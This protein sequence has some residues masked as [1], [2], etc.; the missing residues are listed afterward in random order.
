MQP[1]QNPPLCS[2]TVFCMNSDSLELS[3]ESCEFHYAQSPSPPPPP[4]TLR[5]WCDIKDLRYIASSLP[6]E[7]AW[8]DASIPAGMLMVGMV[9]G[10]HRLFMTHCKRFTTTS[11][12]KGVFR[13]KIILKIWRQNA[14]KDPKRYLVFILLKLFNSV[15]HL[16]YSRS[17]MFHYWGIMRLSTVNLMTQ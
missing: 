10:L 17:G 1:S 5:T 12:L 11:S 2:S 7:P 14:D 16:R 9:G 8:F 6:S 3:S 4:P 13:G 15:S